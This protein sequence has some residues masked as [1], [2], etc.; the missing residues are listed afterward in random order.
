MVVQTK[1]VGMMEQ[2][3]TEQP[4]AIVLAGGEGIRL[5]G[6]TRKIDGDSRPKQF[7]R[8]FGNRSLLGHTRER[9]RPVFD[10]NRV[11]FVVTK[12]HE[13]FYRR[14]AFGCGSRERVWSNRRIAGPEWQSSRRCFNCCN[15]NR[16]RLSASSL[17]IITMQTTMRLRRPSSRRSTSARALR[18]DSSDRR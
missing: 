3:A 7:S 9:L 5:K 8:I 17:Q 16:T 2:F 15:T 13:N 4:W 6:L 18:L 14:R 1:K 10:D 12:D 11:M